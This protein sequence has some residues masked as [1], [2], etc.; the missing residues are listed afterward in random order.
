MNPNKVAYFVG[1][2]LSKEYDVELE[3]DHDTFPCPSWWKMSNGTFETGVESFSGVP[4]WL[5]HA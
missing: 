4:L 5:P 3:E 2:S 1:Q